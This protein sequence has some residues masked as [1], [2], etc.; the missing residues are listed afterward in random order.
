MCDKRGKHAQRAPK[1]DG[2]TPSERAANMT[3]LIRHG[4]TQ[5][6]DGQRLKQGMT[7]TVTSIPQSLLHLWF[8]LS[9]PRLMGPERELAE[10]GALRELDLK[11]AVSHREKGTCAL[12]VTLEAPGA[13][14]ASRSSPCAIKSPLGSWMPTST[15]ISWESLWSLDFKPCP[16]APSRH[17]QGHP[18]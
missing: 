10:S 4:Q 15:L 13:G 3:N 11:P 14:H 8:L 1:G 5:A 16:R 18:T 9:Q 2:G 17:I 6:G 12:A 7:A